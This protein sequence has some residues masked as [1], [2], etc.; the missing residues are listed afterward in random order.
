MFRELRIRLQ[1]VFYQFVRNRHRYINDKN[2]LLIA[3]LVVG[4]LS[5]FAAVLLKHFVHLIQHFLESGFDVKYENY[6]YFIYPL[7]G[8]LLCVLY[9]RTFHRKSVFDKGLS[10]IIYSISRKSSNL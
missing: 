6:L 5:G 8:I 2:F 7:T 3:S 4:V 10:S 1:V 9:V